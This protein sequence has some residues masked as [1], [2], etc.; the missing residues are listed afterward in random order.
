MNKLKQIVFLLFQDQIYNKVIAFQSVAAF[1]IKIQEEEAKCLVIAEAAQKD[2]DEAIPA[3]NEAMKSLDSLKKNDIAE[4]KAYGK[5]PA[6]VEVVMEAVMIL[7]QSEPSWSEAK[8]QLGDPNFIMS[9][10]DFDKDNIPDK[11]LRKINKYT[12]EPDFQPEKV[13][14]VSGAAKS[15]CMWVRAM[16]TY[17][18]IFRVVQPKRERYNQ[19]MAQLKEKQDA[20]ADAKKKLDDVCFLFIFSFFASLL[21]TQYFFK[22]PKTN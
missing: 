2:L 19:A 13:G 1:Q 9:L 17:G 15:L 5:P 3:L 21:I 6:L 16:E 4:V 10:K 22:D 20:L 11:V 8:R 18:Q 14:T 12:S 7:K